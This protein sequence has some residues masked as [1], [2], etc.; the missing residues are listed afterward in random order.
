M[1]TRRSVHFALELIVIYTNLASINLF[2]YIW[3]VLALQ[4][5]DMIQPARS[6]VQEL[7]KQYNY[8]SLLF[9]SN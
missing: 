9:N 6:N 5:L 1:N 3:Q 2:L 7:G 8:A 4:M